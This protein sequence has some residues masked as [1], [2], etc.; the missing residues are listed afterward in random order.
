MTNDVIILKKI[1]FPQGVIIYM[2]LY[3]FYGQKVENYPMFVISS[4]GGA[5]PRK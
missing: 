4:D 5:L 3:V 1:V 2:V